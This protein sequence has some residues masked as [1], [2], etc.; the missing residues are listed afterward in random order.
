M[1]LKKILMVIKKRIRNVQN[2]SIIITVTKK[3]SIK[4]QNIKSQ[5][6]IRIKMEVD[7]SVIIK[8]RWAHLPL[9]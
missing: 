4:K 2:Q 6:L 3:L 8:M 7:Q 5:T 9:S 1:H